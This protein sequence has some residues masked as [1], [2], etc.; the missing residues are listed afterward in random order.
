MPCY[1]PGA[2]NVVMNQP[3]IYQAAFHGTTSV[4][5]GAAIPAVLRLLLNLTV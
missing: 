2:A 4:A 1:I 5:A 3:G